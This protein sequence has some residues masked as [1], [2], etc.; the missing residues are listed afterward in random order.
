LSYRGIRPYDDLTGT[1]PDAP[2]LS[3]RRPHIQTDFRSVVKTYLLWSIEKIWGGAG[4]V[5]PGPVEW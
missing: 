3:S 1:I 5:P 2:A 4:H